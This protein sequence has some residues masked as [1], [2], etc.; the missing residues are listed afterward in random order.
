MA[1]LD[2]DALIA[3]AESAE[4][5]PEG[6]HA[7]SCESCRRELESTRAL[8]AAVRDVEVPEPSPLFWERFAARV[9]DAVAQEPPPRVS[10]LERLTR[11]A[12]ALALGGSAVAAGLVAV[13]VLDRATPPAPAETAAAVTTAPVAGEV[14]APDAPV[15]EDWELITDVAG[16]IDLDEVSAIGGGV[17]PGAADAALMDLSADERGEIARIIREELGKEQS[18]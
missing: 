6:H 14:N 12:W 7:A 18:S 15:G 8:L 11:P 1:H 5:L 2:R 9:R 3:L 16:S 10:W 13:L 17:S 4:P